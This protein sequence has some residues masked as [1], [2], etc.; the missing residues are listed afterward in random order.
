MFRFIRTNMLFV[1]EVCFINPII[2]RFQGMEIDE[3]CPGGGAGDLD[4]IHEL[5]LNDIAA[6]GNLM[7]LCNQKLSGRPELLQKVLAWLAQSVK[8]GGSNVRVDTM[9]FFNALYGNDNA[10][11]EIDDVPLDRLVGA[12][13]SLVQQPARKE[14]SPL[15]KRITF[16][17]SRHSSFN[18]LRGLVARFRPREVFPNVD[19][20]KLNMQDLFGDLLTSREDI[21]QT[22]E[23]PRITSRPER[24]DDHPEEETPSPDSSPARRHDKPLPVEQKIMKR[25]TTI[26]LTTP[27][28]ARKQGESSSVSSSNK[29]KAP[30]SF[31]DGSTT[32]QIDGDIT[33]ATIRR[34]RAF[35]AALGGQGRSWNRDVHLSSVE[36]SYCDADE[37]VE[38]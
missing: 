17:Y 7:E 12:L 5:E 26:D 23:S 8:Q 33:D 6:V 30:T 22:I 9:A 13:E 16:P 36:R 29:R 10:N 21:L 1:E 35:E 24:D 2:T 18:E 38:L 20:Q 27:S 14:P 34:L 3:T 32:K 31:G 37:E 15:A 4:Q 25:P 19:T 28:M 11:N